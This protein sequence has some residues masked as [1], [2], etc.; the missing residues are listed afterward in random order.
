VYVELAGNVS[1]DFHTN[2]MPVKASWIAHAVKVEDVD[3]ELFPDIERY[4]IL[5]WRRAPTR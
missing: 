1:S 4:A 2:P 3:L 5:L